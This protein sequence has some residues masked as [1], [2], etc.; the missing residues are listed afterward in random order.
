MKV[1]FYFGGTGL[2]IVV[3]VALDTVQQIE[4][5]LITATTKASRAR[6][7]RASAAARAVRVV[8]AASRQHDGGRMKKLGVE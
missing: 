2:M 4:S 1:P 3:G 8:R 5:H 6:A 7:V